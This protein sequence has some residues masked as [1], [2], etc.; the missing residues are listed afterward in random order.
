MMPLVPIGHVV[1]RS[2]FAG[3]CVALL[4]SPLRPAC[5]L[6]DRSTKEKVACLDLRPH[7]S[8]HRMRP[9][10]LMLPHARLLPGVHPI[11]LSGDG[12]PHDT[13]RHSISSASIANRQ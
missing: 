1:A 12:Q 11:G 7:A 13:L 10:T 6:S 2:A 4:A 5:T 9:H 3:L 8:A